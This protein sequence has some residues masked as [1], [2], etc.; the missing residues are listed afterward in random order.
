VG[1]PPRVQVLGL[2]GQEWRDL[3]V[4]P[5]GDFLR[6]RVA[7]LLMKRRPARIVIS[8]RPAGARLL[9]LSPPPGRW[10]LPEVRLWRADGDP[11][12]HGMLP[13]SP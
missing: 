13:S 7:D 8:L 6:A 1:I 12:S 4:E 10:E 11:T 5:T 2:V 9:R 3:T